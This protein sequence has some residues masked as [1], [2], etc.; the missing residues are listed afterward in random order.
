MPSIHLVGSRSHFRVSN[1]Q[2]PTALPSRWP[3]IGGT[4]E[5]SE[6]L[7]I[8]YRYDEAEHLHP[9]FA[10]GYGLS[11]TSFRVSAPSLRIAANA[12]DLAVRVSN[13]GRRS[14]TD[15]VECYLEFPT[16]AGE[17]PLQL[18]AFADANLGPGRSTTVRLGLARSAFEIYENGHFE[19]PSGPFTAF[20]GSSSES[21]SAQIR[22][23]PAAWVGESPLGKRQPA[24]SV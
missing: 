24:P 20:I 19:V 18:R 13:T 12:D 7:D 6:G 14:G 3:G 23:Q 15:V 2:V 16:S 4:V 1:T 22:V 10:F 11:Y 21:F 5:Y 9:L 8:G 17:P